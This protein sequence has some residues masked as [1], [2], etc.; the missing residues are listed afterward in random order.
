MG[1]LM[2]IPKIVIA[3]LFGITR[4]AVTQSCKSRSVQDDLEQR[5]GKYIFSNR[6]SK[7]TMYI[8]KRYDEI[9][10]IAVLLTQEYNVTQRDGAGRP[11]TSL[12]PNIL[13]QIIRKFYIKMCEILDLPVDT[14]ETSDYTKGLIVQMVKQYDKKEVLQLLTT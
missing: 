10:Q 5:L 7:V 3:K 12:K 9:M 8:K 1:C 4:S 2:N 14:H 13:R 11:K 6:E